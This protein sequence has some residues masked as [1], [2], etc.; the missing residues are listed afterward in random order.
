MTQMARFWKNDEMKKWKNWETMKNFKKNWKKTKKWKPFIKKNTWKTHDNESE[1]G[2]KRGQQL[3]WNRTLFVVEI[4]I[5]GSRKEARCVD[6]GQNTE[7]KRNIKG[8]GGHIE[9]KPKATSWRSKAPRV[10][11]IFLCTRLRIEIKSLRFN[12]QGFRFKVVSL[13]LKV[14]TLKV[15]VSAFFS[16]SSRSVIQYKVVFLVVGGTEL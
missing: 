16:T 10:R 8:G 15:Q 3:V 6:K 5:F 14:W 13:R 9:N 7:R 1:N 4:R 11:F 2:A 12:V